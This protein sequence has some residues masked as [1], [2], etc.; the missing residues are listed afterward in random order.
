VSDARPRPTAAD[1]VAAAGR[2]AGVVTHTPLVRSQW[3][4][5][6]TGA[7]VWLKLD[8]AQETGSFKLRGAANA[9]ARLKAARPEVTT[10]MAAS[11]GNHGLGLATAARRLGIRARVHLPRT[12]PDAKRRKLEA[13][14]ADL[15]LAATYDEAEA[16][17]QEERA[18]GATFISAYSDPD[19][20][21][22]AGTVALEMLEA[23]PDLDTFVVPMGGGGLISGVALVVRDRVPGALVVG[24]ETSASP[25]WRSALAAGR[26]VT[27]EVRETIA[28]GLAGNIELD[29]VTFDL[30]RELVDRVVDVDDPAIASAMHD[31]VVN[32]HTVAEGAAATAVAAL[33]QPFERLDLSGRRVGVV[34]SGSNVDRTL[35]DAITNHQSITR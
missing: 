12:A 29:S 6:V 31:L 11:A 25:V 35:L 26:L 17:A 1:V 8:T 5:V 2:I 22:G 3:L 18:A 10:V 15:V 30:V 23:R 9:I 13:L 32:E 24:A 4:S 7:D 21:A 20:I 33:L 28:D 16:R 19:V 14:G 34:L 27:V